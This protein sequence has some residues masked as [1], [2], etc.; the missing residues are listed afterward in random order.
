MKRVAGFLFMSFILLSLFSCGPGET[1]EEDKALPRQVF[2]ESFDSADSVELHNGI[3]V[4]ETGKAFTPGFEGAG[5]WLGD[6]NRLIYPASGIIH[7]EHGSIEF[8][9]CPKNRWHDGQTRQILAVGSMTAFS[10]VK[11]GDSDELRVTLHGK[12]IDFYEEEP[13]LGRTYKHQWRSGWNHVAV[14]WR[15]LGSGPAGEM[16]LIING[17]VRNQMVAKL[18][19]IDNHDPLI[20]GELETGKAA[21][22]IIDELKIYNYSKPYW[23]YTNVTAGYELAP[24]YQLE[25]YPTLHPPGV[26]FGQ[27]FAINSETKIIVG[28]GV[29]DQM[30]FAL[31][32]LNDAIEQTYGF[33]CETGRA[34]EFF[35]RDN[36]IAIGTSS[37]NNLLNI[38]LGEYKIP[39]NEKNPGPDG[40]ILEVVKDGIVIA[41]GDYGGSIKGLLTLAQLIRQHFEGYFPG[42]LIVDYPDMPYR[43][44]EV[45]EGD[46][47]TNELKTRL[48][49]FKAMGLSHVVFNT[50]AY[51]DLDDELIAGRINA[52]FDFAGSVGLDPVPLING[53]SHSAKIIEKC[54]DVGIDCSEDGAEQ[55]YTPAEPYVYE[56]LT[57]AINNTITLLEPDYIHI[58]HDEIR[59]FNKDDRTIAL[60]LSPAELYQNDMNRIIDI[61]HARDG[62]IQVMAWFDMLNPLH[63]GMLLAENAPGSDEPPPALRTIASREVIW[64]PYMDGSID[65]ALQEFYPLLTLMELN[66]GMFGQYVTGPTKTDMIGAYWWIIYGEEYKAIGFLNRVM[67]KEELSSE[68][69]FSLP[70]AAEFAWSLYTP[71]EREEVWYDYAD[72]NETYG[73]LL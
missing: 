43:G 17:E 5:Y 31:S 6:G 22:A 12:S 61:I 29:F 58:G 1:G 66:Q 24:S 44:T 40:Y 49:Y 9:I 67:V 27:G 38:I 15:N 37:N 55:T 60:G 13:F 50:D 42:Y 41:G 72:N 35:S 45:M 39:A 63:H 48:L 16:V 73:G 69:W 7:P 8:W 54:A 68:K 30:A 34:S 57:K 32:A 28:D 46:L 65:Q 18:P 71:F 53:Y 33:R 36:F 59:V 47:L 19:R 2:N 23:E 3:L 21:D 64:C 70:V 4:G 11:A 51:F 62:G 26:L 10:I 14:T 20:I 56:V 52:T 25:V